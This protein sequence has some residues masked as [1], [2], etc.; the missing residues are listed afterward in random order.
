M[1][2]KWACGQIALAPP[3]P[4]SGHGFGGLGRGKGAKQ[5]DDEV[6]AGINGRTHHGARRPK[7]SRPRAE[8]VGQRS[9]RPRGSPPAHESANESW[10]LYR[11]AGEVLG[12]SGRHQTVAGFA[13]PAGLPPTLYQPHDPVM[14]T[15]RFPPPWIEGRQRSE[16]WDVLF[17]GRSRHRPS[18][19]DAHP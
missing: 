6:G 9:N 8:P 12:R 19:R 2:P 11:S 1:K 15:H 16:A 14:E 18:G 7:P 4:L 3:A 5:S 17:P 13:T 10:A